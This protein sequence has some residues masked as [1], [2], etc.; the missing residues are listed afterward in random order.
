MLRVDRPRR[1][2]MMPARTRVIVFVRLPASMSRQRKT[3]AT[4][5]RTAGS[6]QQ[7]YARDMRRARSDP[8][9][10]LTDAVRLFF[11]HHFALPDFHHSCFELRRVSIDY[12]SPLSPLPDT[13]S[14]HSSATSSTLPFYAAARR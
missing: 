13:F 3:I 7:Q 10:C 2:M 11:A 9:R 1:Q 5:V 6:C 4:Q 14:R 8:A 12:A